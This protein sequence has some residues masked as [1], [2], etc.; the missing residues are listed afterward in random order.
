MTLTI[1]S[2]FSGIGGLELGLHMA[3][4]GPVLWQVEREPFCRGVLEK[5][6]PNAERFPFVETVGAHCLR[7]VDII[8]GGFPCTDISVAGK[9]RGIDGP[10]S[11]LWREF[12][13][14]VRELRP[15]YAIVENVSALARR[16]L[17]R[18]LGDLAEAGYDAEW[19]CIRAADVGAPHRRERLFI[20]AYAA[21]DRRDRSSA[22]DGADCELDEPHGRDPAR[23]GDPR[24]PQV[25]EPDGERLEGSEPKRQPMRVLSVAGDGGRDVADAERDAVRLEPERR[26]SH[27]T[28]RGHA[29]PRYDR[30]TRGRAAQPGVCRVSDGI[31]GGLDIRWPAGRGEPQHA[32]EP[33]RTTNVIRDRRAR[34][35]ALGNAVVPQVAAVVGARVLAIERLRRA[36]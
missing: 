11:G 1:G 15:R 4:L 24:R 5:H 21:G 10:Q 17:D 14:I 7:P 30:P 32:W 9:R 34:L 8:C 16:G 28:Q 12:A 3:G 29:E 19:S 2:L 13:R 23:R 25:A 6:W 27:T 22:R 26:E 18:V 35:K 36:A 33:S 20:V 31:S